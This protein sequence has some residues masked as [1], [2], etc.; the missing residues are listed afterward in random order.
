MPMSPTVWGLAN[1]SLPKNSGSS[2]LYLIIM[3]MTVI[4][5]KYKLSLS[6]K[7]KVFVKFFCFIFL[8]SAVLLMKRIEHILKST[9]TSVIEEIDMSMNR[10]SIID[11][12]NLLAP[13][14]CIYL[15]FGLYTDDD[16]SED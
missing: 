3:Q 15:W 12:R 6:M 5:T 16:S 14:G 11:F 7:K 8:K 13:Y 4:D 10:L 1:S 2:H 9:I